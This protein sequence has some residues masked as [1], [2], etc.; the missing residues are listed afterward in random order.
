MSLKIKAKKENKGREGEGGERE[1]SRRRIK[2]F[3][4]LSLEHFSKTS[5]PGKEALRVPNWV[6]H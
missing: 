6:Q 3:W 1:Q 2:S 5:G 4:K